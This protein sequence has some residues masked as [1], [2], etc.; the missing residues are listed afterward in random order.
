M[1]NKIVIM[2]AILGAG[3]CFSQAH[4]E[5]Q[6]APMATTTY[7]CRLSGEVSGVGIA[8]GVG[9]QVLSGDGTLDCENTMTGVRRSTPVALRMAGGGVGFELNAIR[10]VVVRSTV[11]PVS[12]ITKFYDTF[13][14]GA[15][16]GAELGRDGVAY[17]VAIR[18]TSRSG[19]GFDV[20]LQSR[21]VVGLGAHLYAMG[22]E[23][24]PE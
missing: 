5:E 22:F 1:K 11:V 14:I 6:Y 19:L 13:S 18:L 3:L 9:G 23:I 21:D 7:N 2:L 12:D 15:E 20:G 10:S 4:A 16:S 17:D 8:I 24:S